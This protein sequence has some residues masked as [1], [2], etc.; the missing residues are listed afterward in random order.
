MNSIIAFDLQS[1][2]KGKPGFLEKES[3]KNYRV[4]LSRESDFY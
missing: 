3:R 2:A 4:L 1:K